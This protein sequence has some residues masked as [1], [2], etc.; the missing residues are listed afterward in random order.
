MARMR[1]IPPARP[2]KYRGM[3][4]GRGWQNP[5]LII[6]VDGVAL[7]DASNHEELLLK[8]AELTQALAKLPLSAWPYGRVV[9]V[10]ENGVRGAGDDVPRRKNRALVAG[11]LES[12]HV[13]I[14]WIPSA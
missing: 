8:P 1:A 13:L 6:R 5:Y 10:T 4:D 14:N 9:A 7:L 3:V 2:E 11:T 12:L